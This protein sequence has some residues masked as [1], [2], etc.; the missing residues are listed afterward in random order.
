MLFL[1]KLQVHVISM[2]ELKKTPFYDKHVSLGARMVD[3]EG[4]LMP[5]Q[6]KGVSEEHLNCRSK[7]SV[8]DISHMGEFMLTGKD[9]EKFLNYMVTNDVSVL[10]PNMAQYACLC[11]PNGTVVDDLFYYRYSESKFRIIVNASNMQKDF[12]WFLQHKSGFD[13]ELKN[14]SGERARLA[15]QGPTTESALNPITDFDLTQLKRFGFVETNLKGI[16]I[17][18]ARTGYTGEDGFELSCSVK[19]ALKVWDLIFESGKAHG[20]EPAGLGARDTLRLEACYSLYGHEINNEI[21]PIEASIGWAVKDKA[22]DFIGKE[23]LLK[24]KKEG[25]QRTLRGLEL[26]DKGILRRGYKVFDMD[27][28]EIGF[29]TSGAFGPSVNKTIALAL[30]KTESSQIGT[31]LK[32]QIREKLKAT[33]IVQTPW[34]SYKKK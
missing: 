29:I 15:I 4:W 27:D 22:C 13:V 14:E 17:F 12:E 25:T 34:V 10:K 28:R 19:D 9:A 24:Q 7:C 8:F 23:I 30:I 21:T 2:Q 1:V 26:D 32:V 6:Y 33:K 5:V 20:L 11:Y 31:R 3:F 18:I 16:P